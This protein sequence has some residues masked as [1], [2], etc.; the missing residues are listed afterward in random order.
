MAFRL[1][2]SP[3]TW[4]TRFV[5]WLGCDRNPLRRTSDRLEARLVLLAIVGY[6]PLAM[7][8]ASYASHW[9]YEAGVR[10]QHV[11]PAR[12]VAAVVLTSVKSTKPVA[13]TWVPVRWTMGSR[14]H[15]DTAPVSYGVPAGTTIRVWVDQRDRVTPPPPTTRQLD[16]QVLTAKV[17]APLLMAQILVLSLLAL[18]WYLNRQRFARWDSEWG[19]ID[20]INSR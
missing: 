11:V 17:L 19:L 15:T 18:R 2:T 6:A 7:L 4:P 14:T 10:A 9:V 13:K 20:A 16:D 8:A 1:V 3:L 12:P 5:R